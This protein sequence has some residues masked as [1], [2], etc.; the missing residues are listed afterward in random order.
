MTVPDVLLMIGMTALALWRRDRWIY[1]I[2]ALAI[3][4]MAFALVEVDARA[5]VA[6]FGLALYMFIKGIW[7]V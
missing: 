1:F 7:G 6:P 3:G 2:A 5:S 4:F